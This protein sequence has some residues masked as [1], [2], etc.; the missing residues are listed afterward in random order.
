MDDEL[1]TVFPLYWSTDL[2]V[3]L[4][5]MP[6]G[7]FGDLLDLLRSADEPS[8]E[9]RPEQLPKRARKENKDDIRRSSN[10]VHARNSRMR[11]KFL[12]ESLEKTI[13]ALKKENEALKNTVKNHLPG[14]GD[15]ILSSIA[16]PQGHTSN[17]TA[18]SDVK[19]SILATKEED[20]NAILTA[21]DYSLM[22]ALQ[23][24]GQTFLITDPKREDN[25]IIYA[26]QSFFKLT[27]Y[28]S[29][30]V[31]GRNCRFL[32]GPL[33]D[34]DAVMR[35][36]KGVEEGVDTTERLLN[37]RKDGSTFWN[38]LFVAPLKDTAGNIVHFLGVQCECLGPN[39]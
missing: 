31:L 27:G 20:A 24:S 32:Q 11:K 6:E 8:D 36:R 25:P 3:D 9:E 34:R 23:T 30:E 4:S 37:Y 2:G 14:E 29:S 5:P 10:R 7:D 12:T 28:S 39:A 19:S 18:T 1:E 33:T 35:I 17:G 15:A 38:Q 26:S 13:A 21:P 22:K 16:R